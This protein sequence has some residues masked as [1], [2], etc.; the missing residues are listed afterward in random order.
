V[1]AVDLGQLAEAAFAEAMRHPARSPRRRAASHAWASM[2]VPPAKSITGARNAIASF[3]D[4]RTQADAL[5][6]L[7]RLERI[8]AEN[9]QE[10][11]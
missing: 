5:E 8:T 1:T 10:P 4:E 6:L 9:E 7:G 11:A 2:T 3:G